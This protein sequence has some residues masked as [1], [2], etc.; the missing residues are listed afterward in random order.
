MGHLGRTSGASSQSNLI[1]AQSA[2]DERLI[3]SGNWPA[4]RFEREREREKFKTQT[5][6]EVEG[7]DRIGAL[8]PLFHLTKRRQEV[9]V[10]SIMIDAPAIFKL[11]ESVLAQQH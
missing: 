3:S 8:F 2:I 1:A 5:E 9:E 4:I 7:G 10:N 6:P 11:P